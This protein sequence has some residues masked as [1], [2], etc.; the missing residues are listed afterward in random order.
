MVPRV[1]TIDG[2][3]KAS[4]SSRRRGLPLHA[5]RSERRGRMQLLR[6]LLLREDAVAPLFALGLSLLV[7]PPPLTAPHLILSALH[8][9][10]SHLLP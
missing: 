6:A 10:L 1:C 7:P 8:H 5:G 2:P 9:V 3:R 4:W